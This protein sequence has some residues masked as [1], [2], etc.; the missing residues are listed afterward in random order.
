[1]AHHLEDV[2]LFHNTLK[3]VRLRSARKDGDVLTTMGRAEQGH[4]GL[5]GKVGGLGVYRRQILAVV[6]TIRTA[7]A[8]RIAEDGIGL[9]ILG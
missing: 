4:S 9:F 8:G 1:M 6:F 2:A 3:Q 7:W 5:L